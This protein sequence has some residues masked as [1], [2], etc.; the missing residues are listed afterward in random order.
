STITISNVQDVFSN[1]SIADYN[2]TISNGNYNLS[3]STTND[4][5]T[6]NVVDLYLYNVSVI[7]PEFYE[8]T[9]Q[10]VNVT[11][12]TT[13]NPFVS[14]ALFSVIDVYNLFWEEIFDSNYTVSNATNTWETCAVG[15]QCPINL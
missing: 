4:S 10:N 1:V 6:L 3:G 14:R 8:E 12:N 9:Y 5:V 7:G 11:T 15:E 2:V 13:I